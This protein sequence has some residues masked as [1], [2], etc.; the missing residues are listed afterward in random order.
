MK[1]KK[2]KHS[3]AVLAAACSSVVLS[4]SVFAVTPTPD[5]DPDPN[6]G[7]NASFSQLFDEAEGD[8]RCS[9]RRVSGVGSTFYVP[10]DPSNRNA[11][12]NIL[13]W[14]N[15]T[16]GT[17]TTYSS[18]LESIA[19]HCILVAAAN[20]ANSGTG[21]EVEDAVD[22]ARSRY[23]DILNSNAKVCTSG[24]SQ[25]G[26]GSFNAAN[27]LD[28]DCV[29]AVQPDT[30]YTTQIDDA[31][32]RDVEVIAFWSDGDTLAPA[33]PYNSRRVERN[34]SILTQ[35]E[36]DGE[37]H[38]TITYGRGGNIGT[39]FRMASKAQLS[40]DSA[41]ATKFR[42]AFWGP[43]TSS[44]VTTSAR[45]ISDVERDSGATSATP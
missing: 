42:K 44:T 30:V 19:S 37:D 2:A 4:S 8:G 28:A 25:G 16:G 31:L 13:G 40:N 6:P 32:P 15:G 41:E 18:V 27:R 24:H 21:R 5:P 7:G 22:D 33:S 26:G 11:R 10:T 45:E 43:S 38:F 3:L 35:V 36:T 20:T 17:S 9:V 29:I 23:S 14:G 39:L 34:S 1:N 12:F